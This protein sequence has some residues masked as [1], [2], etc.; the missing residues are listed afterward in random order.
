M[1]KI[2]V[3]YAK[4][5]LNKIISKDYGNYEVLADEDACIPMTTFRNSANS[6]E[7][8]LHTGARANLIKPS[9]GYAFERMHAF[10]N[11]ISEEI[12]KGNYKQFNKL[13]LKTKKDF[14]CMIDFY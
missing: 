8:I 7:G 10:A 9:T 5:I 12:L 13:S 14:V 2:D 11:R 4:E 3:A 6:S 1:K